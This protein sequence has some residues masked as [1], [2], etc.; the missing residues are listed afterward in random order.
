MEPSPECIP[1]AAAIPIKAG[2]ICLV[3]ARSN[4]NRW[5][6]PK[7]KIDPGNTAEE[8]ARQILGSEFFRREHSA[9]LSGVK[10]SVGQ[11]G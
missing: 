3:T 1:Q 6:I 9:R 2:R 4:G 8:T 5:V 10:A 7:G 11:G